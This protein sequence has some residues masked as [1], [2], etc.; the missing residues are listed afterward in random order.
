M[1][2]IAAIAAMIGMSPSQLAA[3]SAG[4]WSPPSSR[5]AAEIASYRDG[6]ATAFTANLA[7]WANFQ[8]E[9]LLLLTA[10]TAGLMMI[11]LALFK[12]GFLTE[13]APTHVYRRW[14]A[15]GASALAVLVW[16]GWDIVRQ[17]FPLL[18][19][20][21]T[22]TLVTAALVPLI[23]LGYASALILILRAGVFRPVMRLLAAM[24]RMAFTNYLTHS[25]VLSTLFWG[26]RGLGLYGKLSRP[27]LGLVVVVLFA[28]QAAFSVLWLR[29][30]NHGPF[31]WAWRRLSRADL[32]PRP[33]VS[34]HTP[35]AVE[36][37]SL[38]KRFGKQVAV[39][40]VDLRVPAGAIYAFIGPNGAGK[41]TTIRILLGL[42]RPTRGMGASSATTSC[43]TG[44]GLCHVG[45]LLESC[46]TYDHLS[47][48]ENLDITV[49]AHR[50]ARARSTGCCR[51]SAF[52]TLRP[53]GSAITLWACA[54]GWGSPVR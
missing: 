17:G 40:D 9:V 44:R 49:P 19:M 31:E 8:I 35:P 26:G 11:G 36:T 5:L 41:T 22:G 13:S 3:F 18:R 15:I 10:R 1:G 46:A 48:L 20:Q 37:D 53:G 38:T 14:L 27:E 39:A 21:V 4:S 50:P 51:W 6:W 7:A 16:N 43:R 12:T 23:S 28:A 42:M 52:A 25:I 2:L 24:G 33:A 54:S 34:C 30:F 47:G 32:P 29:C 45:A